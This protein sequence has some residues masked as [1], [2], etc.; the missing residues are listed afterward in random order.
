MLTDELRHRLD[1]ITVEPDYTSV[2]ASH[3]KYSRDKGKKN[4]QQ[5]KDEYLEGLL[6][7]EISSFLGPPGSTPPRQTVIFDAFTG[8]ADTFAQFLTTVKSNDNRSRKASKNTRAI[9]P[10]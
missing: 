2:I 4:L 8:S 9:N 5:R 10:V 6:C 7:A 1:D 3:R